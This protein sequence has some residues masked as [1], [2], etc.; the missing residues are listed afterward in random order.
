MNSRV[1]IQKSLVI[2]I[3]LFSLTGCNEQE[4]YEKEFLE[5]AGVPDEQILPDIN[6]D[7][8][9]VDDSVVDDSDDDS[10]G[11]VITTPTS[12]DDSDDAD[13][14]DS[15]D[16]DS[17]D[18]DDADSGD[19]TDGGNTDGG[20]NTDGGNTDG[21]DNT[22]GGN[23]DGGDNTDGGNNGGGGS[24]DEPDDE[25]EVVVEPGL[26]GEG[27]LTNASDQFIQNT[28][29]EA[30][31]DILWVMDNSGSM[32]D[33]Q[34]AL[35]DNFDAFISDFITRNIDFQMAITT[36]DGRRNSGQMVGDSDELTSIAAANN[37]NRFMNNFTDQINVGIRGSGDEMGIETSKDFF[38]N[39]R[40][41]AREDA[42][43]IVVYI[44]D[45]EDNSRGFVNDYISNLQSLK[46][47]AG[48]VK[49]YSI[50]TTELDPNKQWESVGERYMEVSR[51][52]GGEIASIH[53]DFHETLSGFGFKIL[54]LL[55]SFP[56]SGVPVGTELSVTVNNQELA[57]GWTYDE[58]SRSIKFDENAIPNE[59][60]IIIAY[61]QKCVME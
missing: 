57:Q 2:F 39:Y 3:V 41:W 12:P 26:C 28:A 1:L 61:Y 13:S 21:G 24:T 31:V 49:A 5:G 22:D 4:F 11:G 48:M 8:P 30:K 6:P 32:S 19:N 14:D 10:V 37:V 15:D 27:T 43:L 50:V 34:Q 54:D 35:S 42:Y 56:L 38:D 16:A 18:N 51:A 58:T 60:E 46:A 47:S 23:T 53:Q 44:S 17:E 7:S 52:T 29:Q 40:S 25:D 45:E 20:D 9:V 59:G 55:D 33:E 36:T